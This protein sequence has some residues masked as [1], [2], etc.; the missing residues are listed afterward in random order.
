MAREG[1]E[2]ER[3]SEGRSNVKMSLEAAPAFSEY[4][5]E[6]ASYAFCPLLSLLFGQN[7]MWKC[8]GGKREKQGRALALALAAPPALL[9]AHQSSAELWSAGGPATLCVVLCSVFQDGTDVTW[10]LKSRRGCNGEYFWQQSPWALKLQPLCWCFLLES[11]GCCL[12][13]Q[14]T[15]VDPTLNHLLPSI[16]YGTVGLGPGLT[17]Q[18][19]AYNVEPNS[20]LGIKPLYISSLQYC[21]RSD[22]C[23]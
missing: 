13:C 21:L 16:K 18:R 5:F 12:V 11:C 9:T 22:K 6:Y 3:G 20:P 8:G 14:L 2:K 17:R 7:S 10:T 4:F 23:N 15:S 1:F 19:D